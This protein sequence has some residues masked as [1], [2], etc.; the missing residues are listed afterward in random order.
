VTFI[1]AFS[2]YW[3]LLGNAKRSWFIRASCS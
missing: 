2:A 3:L 1:S